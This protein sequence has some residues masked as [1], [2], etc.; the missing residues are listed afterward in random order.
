M[1]HI[2]SF[3]AAAATWQTFYVLIGTAAATLM[4]LMF[5]A[6][7]FGASLV[8]AQSTPTARAFLDP[9]FYHFASALVIA[10]TV[11]VPTMSARLLG[12]M[13]LAGALVRVTSLL[14]TFRHM[15]AAQRQFNDIELSDWMTAIVLPFVC[16]LVL[17]ASGAGFIAGYAVAFDGTAAATIAILVLG[18][19]G[20]WELMLWLALTRAQRGA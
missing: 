17:A 12:G 5:V 20:A 19:V 4:G 10:C 18:I 1:T 15:R 11:V 16:Y 6:V 14:R 8:S 7:T 3:A 9:P 13:L 2:V